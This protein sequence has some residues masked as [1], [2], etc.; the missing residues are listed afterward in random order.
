MATYGAHRQ[1]LAALVQ[2]NP[3]VRAGLIVGSRAV[4]GA[5][6]AADLDVVLVVDQ[7]EA[8]LE[9]PKWLGQLGRI[10]AWATDTAQAGL[11]VL[12]VLLD[13]AAAIDFII[14]GVDQPLE[15]SFRALAA[16]SLRR[17]YVVLKDELELTPRLEALADAAA[18]AHA[19]G[20]RPTQ[21]EF[22]DTV[23]GFWIDAVRATKLL[24]RGEVWA[25]AHLIEARMKPRLI[26][27]EGWAA[28]AVHGAPYDT[29]WAGR[30]L[31]HWAVGSFL[32]DFAGT[33]AA[34]DVADQRRALFHTMD[35]FRLLAV[36]TAHRWGL[37]YPEAADMRATVWARTWQ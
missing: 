22:A 7:P 8:F 30:H 11:P 10:W 5:D 27:V 12:R 29:Y 9:S 4:E 36:E 26:K 24:G 3:S 25:A 1:Q 18:E 20:E 32:A 23:A 35:V 14:W 31:E 2:D 37:D 16:D 21:E 6:E 13:G 17:G 33:F 15:P 19:H 28:R 34:F